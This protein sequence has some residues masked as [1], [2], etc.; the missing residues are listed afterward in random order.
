MELFADGSSDGE[1]G[2]GFMKNEYLVDN[3]RNS[4][5]SS[6]G[7]KSGYLS[8]LVKDMGYTH[9]SGTIA[10]PKDVSP[11]SVKLSAQLEIYVDEVLVLRSEEFTNESKPQPFDIDITGAEVIK[12][13]WS[14]K[15]TNIWSN[16]GYYATIFDPYVADDEYFIQQNSVTSV[17]TTTSSS[18]SQY[19]AN[20]EL[21]ADGSSDG[22]YGDGFIKNE[23][24][25]DNYNNSYNSSIGVKSGY[26][27][28]LV[29][30]MGYTHFSGTI[31]LPKKVSPDSVKLSAQLEIYVDEVLECVHIST[32]QKNR[33]KI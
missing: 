28:Y 23:Y 26:L 14:S 10:L 12:I 9:F 3:Y 15:G 31:V 18:N 25:V 6:I 4:Y 8:Y 7:V 2:D 33:N 30:D 17:E 27:S 19:L 21:F 11:D 1:Y 5:S 16:W 29:K 22:A 24:L 13:T 20:M 32:L